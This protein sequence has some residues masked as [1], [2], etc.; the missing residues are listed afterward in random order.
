MTV[1]DVTDR[2]TVLTAKNVVKVEFVNIESRW[3]SGVLKNFENG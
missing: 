2:N 3:P 1:N